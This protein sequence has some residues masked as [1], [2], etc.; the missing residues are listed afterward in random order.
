MPG[1][2][3]AESSG[4]QWCRRRDSPFQSGPST[5][6]DW[7]STHTCI[8][9]HCEPLNA[10]RVCGGAWR[11]CGGST[12]C[13]RQPAQIAGAA[14]ARILRRQRSTLAMSRGSPSN[15]ICLIS[16]GWRRITPA[17]LLRRRLSDPRHGSGQGSSGDD[18]TFLAPGSSIGS[19]SS[20][21]NRVRM[22]LGSARS[23]NAHRLVRADRL[24]AYRS[25]KAFWKHA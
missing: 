18:F 9:I 15:S 21:V 17:R 13:S 3:V 11:P 25:L 6:R 4:I 20:L 19:A 7:L 1:D 24:M 5:P 23:Q 16:S 14:S 8:G 22:D 10:R 2:T 12:S